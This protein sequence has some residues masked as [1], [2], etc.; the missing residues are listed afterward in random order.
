MM[1]KSNRVMI[2]YFF[3]ASLMWF[4]TVCVAQPS[5]VNDIITKRLVKQPVIPLYV[6]TSNPTESW[7]ALYS[8]FGKA[9]LQQDNTTVDLDTVQVIAVDLAFTDYPSSDDL[10]K[11]NTQRL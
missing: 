4:C 9:D 6:N 2:K 11:L 5:L 3:S 10:V 1:R 8:A 7:L